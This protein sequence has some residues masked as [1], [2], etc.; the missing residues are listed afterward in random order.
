[1][2]FKNTYKTDGKKRT[3]FVHWLEKLEIEFSK[4]EIEEDWNYIENI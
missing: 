3:Q 1:M 4:D 2:N